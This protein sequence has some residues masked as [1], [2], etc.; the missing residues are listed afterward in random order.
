MKPLMVAM[1][2]Q[3]PTCLILMRQAQQ[4][5]EATQL[6][7]TYPHIHYTTGR[8]HKEHSRHTSQ[9]RTHSS[10]LSFMLVTRNLIY[11]LTL[12]QLARV[13]PGTPNLAYLEGHVTQLETFRGLACTRGNHSFEPCN[14][15]PILYT[16]IPG[17][18]LRYFLYTS[19][20]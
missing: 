2:L 5:Q 18:N 13:S 15:N 12:G 3:G 9:S 8:E 4:Q 20:T 16:F 7:Y 14:P 1:M 17:V 10:L 11:S 19:A 6:L